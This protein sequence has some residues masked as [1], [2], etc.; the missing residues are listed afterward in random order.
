[1]ISQMIFFHI[2]KERNAYP[3]IRNVMS[4]VCKIA[5]QVEYANV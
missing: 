1:M 3:I 2:S 5:S 4:K